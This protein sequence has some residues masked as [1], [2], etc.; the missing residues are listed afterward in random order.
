MEGL[1]VSLNYYFFPQ[2]WELLKMFEKG[3]HLI[4]VLFMNNNLAVELRDRRH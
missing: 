1:N 2:T 3:K 4:I